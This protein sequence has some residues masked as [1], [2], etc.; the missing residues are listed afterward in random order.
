[1]IALVDT[2][3][4]VLDNVIYRGLGAYIAIAKSVERIMKE[5]GD[6]VNV[7]LVLEIPTRKL[8]KVEKIMRI[9]CGFEV[10]SSLKD[11]YGLERTFVFHKKV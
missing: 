2:S 11:C 7:K 9:G 10:E 6:M 3:V 4:N 1:M 5:C 8:K